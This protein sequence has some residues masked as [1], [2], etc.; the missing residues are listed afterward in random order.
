MTDVPSGEL[1]ALK[2]DRRAKAR[3]A[4]SILAAAAPAGAA[5]QAAQHFLDHI[6]L[7]A[8][9]VLSGYWPV[10]DE[11]DPRPL[12]QAALQ[13]GLLIG[14]PVVS[15]DAPLTFRQWRP[16]ETLEPAVMGIPVPAATAAS[17]V[18][19]VL[20]VPLLA[21]D[22]AGYR[23]G[24][25]GGYYDRT[26]GALRRGERPVLAVGLAYAGQEVADVPHH[27]FDQPLDWVVTE[28]EARKFQ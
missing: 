18:P 4:R 5:S 26:L 12:M 23:L 27:V 22:A 19:E 10:G 20:I 21:F 6:P 2:R 9:L 7:R 13:Q 3:S 14:L 8:G 25:G 1:A 28:R 24:Y 11:G 17:V 15:R 16:G